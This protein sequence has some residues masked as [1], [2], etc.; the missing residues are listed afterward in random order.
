M[1]YMKTFERVQGVR[2][3]PQLGNPNRP[4]FIELLPFQG[5]FLHCNKPWRILQQEEN[6]MQNNTT[7]R[8]VRQL[9]LGPPL[10][11]SNGPETT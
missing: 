3:H 5:M 2:G 10:M 6:F 9:V 8:A 4:K 7:N 11:G 1:W